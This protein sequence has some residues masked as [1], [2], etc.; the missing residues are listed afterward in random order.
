MPDSPRPADAA[1][2]SCPFCGCS[3]HLRIDRTLRDGYTMQTED[4]DAFAF[5]IHC[6]SCAATGGWAKSEAGAR[7]WWNMRARLSE[8]REAGEERKPRAPLGTCTAMGKGRRRCTAVATKVYLNSRVG[9][10]PA[11]LARCDEHPLG[12]CIAVA[13][14][15]PMFQ[16]RLGPS[17]GEPKENTSHE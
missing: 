7:R 5:N 15:V 1:L 9:M 2:R 6:P 8:T 13:T 10:K 4:P 3:D 11:R 14:I 17:T 16:P 12:N